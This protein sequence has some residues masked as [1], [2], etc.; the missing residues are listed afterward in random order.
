MEDEKNYGRKIIR[1]KK[2]RK[3]TKKDYTREFFI[4]MLIATLIGAAI[5]STVTGIIVHRADTKKEIKVSAKE[6][7]LVKE[8]YGAEDNKII[9]AD[10]KFTW[11][12]GT[13]F[14]FVPLDVDMDDD[15][16]QF[17]YCLTYAYDMDFSLIMA[18]IEHESNFRADVV[19][20]TGD[21]GLMQ[22]NK[23]NH[24]WLSKELG[25]TDF[26]DEKQNIRAGVYVIRLLFQKYGNDT[27]KVLM[28]YNM[29]EANAKRL[30]KE[31]IT[32][33][34]YSQEITERQHEF[35]EQIK[36]ERGD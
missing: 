18:M 16:Q 8:V 2:Y 32:S 29:G 20:N 5:G 22:I 21:Y 23:A 7:G 9:T 13:D 15:L 19:S 33:S 17:T 14:G 3:H 1:S 4:I 11:S 24:K 36:A 12:E 10:N 28:A 31:G 30:W 25:V 27:N 6:T 26:L 34:A 35:Q